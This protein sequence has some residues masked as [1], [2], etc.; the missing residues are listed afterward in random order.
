MHV[1]HLTWSTASRHPIA[2]QEAD[3]RALVRLLGRIAGDS[4]A[5][6]CIAD[7]HLHVVLFCT[8]AV[9]GRI[10]QALSLALAAACSETVCPAHTRRVEERSHLAWLANHY[11]LGQPIKHGLAS[12]PALWSGSCFPDLAGARVIPGLRLRIFEALPRWR[13]GDAFVAVGL[14]RVPL[15]PTG[16]AL[17]RGLGAT[18]VVAGVASACAG[19]AGLRGKGDCE[20][21]GRLA[22]ARICSAATISTGEIAF[23][24]G[25]TPQA[26][27]RLIRRA[28]DAGPEAAGPD[29]DR[30]AA[31]ARLHL[32]LEQVVAGLPAISRE[33]DPT[34]V[35]SVGPVGRDRSSL[36]ALRTGRPG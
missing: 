30:L 23:S 26:V 10:A 2:A 16:D 12:H 7:D 25:I 5:L 28:A 9:R 15:I 31:A 8:E 18:R 21:L 29:L 6:F 13:L 24:L 35:P 3:R 20:S 27:N 11:I 34:R 22:A 4:V 17:A 36:L 19:D 33:P 1:W 14:P 32:A